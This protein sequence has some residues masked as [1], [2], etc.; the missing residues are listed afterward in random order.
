M[1]FLRDRS[2]VSAIEFAF[3]APILMLVI[4][5]MIDVWSYFNASLGARAAVKAGAN[6]V[7]LGGHT[8]STAQ[9]VAMSAWI[10]A[11]DDATVSVE[12]VCN[13]G[14]EVAACDV[15]CTGTLAPPAGYI[16]IEAAGTWIPPAP[17]RFLLESR[18]IANHQVIRVR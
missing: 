12:Q 15:L 9:A 7:L 13:C 1:H 3:V 8:S 10:H 6:Y 11:P 16:H 5:A 18:P 14:D 2:G 17:I 4:L